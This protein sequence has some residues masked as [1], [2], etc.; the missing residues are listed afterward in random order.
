[1]SSLQKLASRLEI[2]RAAGAIGDYRIIQFRDQF[3]V[4]V[5]PGDSLMMGEELQRFV[6]EML[7][8][9]IKP[10]QI[11]IRSAEPRL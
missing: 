4:E 9:D 7:G 5:S 1:M 11:R 2:L 3:G 8:S 6:V 10:E